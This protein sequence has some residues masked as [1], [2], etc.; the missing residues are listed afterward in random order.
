MEIAY[1]HGYGALIP[2]EF[3]EEQVPWEKLCNHQDPE[4]IELLNSML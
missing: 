2:S 4:A 3:P 1:Y